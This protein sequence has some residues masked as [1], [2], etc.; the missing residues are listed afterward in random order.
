MS[1]VVKKEKVLFIVS[2]DGVVIS[3]L[4]AIA[5]ATFGLGSRRA[6]FLYTH[7]KRP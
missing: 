4:P 6:E 1:S 2:G 3:L 5:L 7:E